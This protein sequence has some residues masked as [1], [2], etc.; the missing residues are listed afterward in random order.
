MT[1]GLTVYTVY[2]DQKPF[3]TNIQLANTMFLRLR[4]LLHRRI[5]DH[6]EGLLLFPCDQ[7]HSLGMR[8]TIDI[9]FLDK[10]LN[11]LKIETL[12]PGRITAR[13]A[14]SYSVLEVACGEAAT[15]GLR[16]GD[17]LL[18]AP[19]PFKEATAQ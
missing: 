1:S 13:V 4:G 17:Q 12:V 14:K 19:N 9:I 6:Q 7:V 11:I 2:K 16:P 5:L 15:R 18:F 8:M 3:W 10:S